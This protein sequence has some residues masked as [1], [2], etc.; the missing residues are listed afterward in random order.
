M[1]GTALA[2][3]GGGASVESVCDAAVQ[4]LADNRADIPFVAIYT[5][6]PRDPVAHLVSSMGMTD[7]SVFT[8]AVYGSTSGLVLRDIVNTGASTVLD[9]VP[10]SWGE[11][12]E[13]GANPVGDQPPTT[14]LILPV[15]SSG[16]DLPATVMVAGVTPYRR[17]DDDFRG[18]LDLATAQINRAI[19]DAQA[20]TAERVKSQRSAMLSRLASA[21]STTTSSTALLTTAAEQLGTMFMADQVVVAIWNRDAA[22]DPC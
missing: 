8:P 4:A 13:P 9:A 12:M 14:A 2:A 18:Y 16:P 22:D 10:S 19:G 15:Q 1:N 21:L 7:P 3:T 6:N 11:A 17:L 20:F 5:L